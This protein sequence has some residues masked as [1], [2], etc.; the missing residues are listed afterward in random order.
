MLPTSFPMSFSQVRSEFLAP[1]SARFSQ[2]LRGGPY[3]PNVSQNQNVPT[4][5]P[6]RLSQLLGAQRYVPISLTK[7]GDAIGSEFRP[8]PAPSFVNVTTNSVTIYPAGGNGSYTCT[9]SQAGGAGFNP[10]PAN[11]FTGAWTASLMKNTTR[12][13]VMRCTVSDGVSSA[14][15]DVN[16]EMEYWTDL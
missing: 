3:V 7:S 11:Q 14:F 9:W 16:V 6:M 13:G 5:L 1:L 2:F 10:P 15:I 4:A 12:T 8:E